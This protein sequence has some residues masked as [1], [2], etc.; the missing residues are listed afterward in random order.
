ML[1]SA[2]LSPVAGALGQQNGEST[3]D[4]VK[5][6]GTLVV[7]IQTQGAPFGY[8]DDQGRNVGFDADM[9]RYIAKKLGT[10]IEFR[11]VTSATRMPL[12]A[13]RA[14]DIA[15]A[16]ITV[17]PEREKVIDFSSPYVTMGGKL[18][19]KKS[20]AI[21][22]LQ[23]L[24]GK[25]VSFALG[26]TAQQDVQRVVPDIKPVVFNDPPLAVQAVIQNKA[27]AMIADGSQLY[28]YAQNNPTLMVTGDAWAPK[29]LA[30]GLRKDDP[31]WRHEIDAVLADFFCR[32]FV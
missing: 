32:W 2:A 20:S 8:L 11:Q 3:L 25:P 17:T 24:H 27:A 9:A 6:R 13:S 7:G 5:Q 26:G 4:A 14:I 18:L 31:R 15:A 12:L 23:D 29:P 16:S 22:S 30:I 10:R 28:Y 1:M 21:R 19:V